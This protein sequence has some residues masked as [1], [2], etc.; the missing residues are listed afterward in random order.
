M[1]RGSAVNPLHA[2]RPCS[3]LMA[4]TAI[5]ATVLCSCR[6]TEQMGAARNGPPPVPPGVSEAIA[7]PAGAYA[8]LPGQA[9]AGGPAGGPAGYPGG[10]VPVVVVD[11]D[12]VPMGPAPMPYTPTGP[13]SPPGISQPWPEDEYLADGGDKNLKVRVGPQWQ[14]QGLEMEDTVAHFDTVDGQTQVEP[15]NQVHIYSPRFR[16][17]RQVVSVQASEQMNRAADV[18]LPTRLVRH[19]D[20]QKA[21]SAKQQI[22]ADRDVGTKSLTVYRSRQGNGV[23]STVLGPRGFQA[24]FLPY[25][26]LSII[27]LGAFRE[28]EM[29]HLAKGINAA[30]AWSHTQAVQVILDLE[31]AAEEVRDEKVGSVYSVKA[32]QGH[33]KLRIIKVASTHFAEPGDTLDFTLR[34]DNVGDQPIG[35]VTI[36]DNLSPRLEYVPQSAQCN[37]PAQFLTQPNE[38]GSQVLR[39]EINDPMTPGQ[40]GIIRFR[41]QVR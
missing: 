23:M 6:G 13:W 10:P 9:Y 41:C 4:L 8:A 16:A 7:A 40:G 25:E 22:Q 24:G 29:A 21:Q 38:G 19:E 36:L 3:R 35:N 18:H 11:A 39:W 33:P 1:N 37:V 12:G 31:K 14:V 27:R 30:I 20:L 2:H 34:F 32:R 17:V 5:C 28:A 15:S 26:D